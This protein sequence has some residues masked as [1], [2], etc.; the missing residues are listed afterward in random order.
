M[1]ISIWEEEY[2]PVLVPEISKPRARRG[3]YEIDDDTYERWMKAFSDFHN[4][5]TEIKKMLKEQNRKHR[6]SITGF[7]LGE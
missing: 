4:M 3:I 6:K 5:Q 7:K 2:Y 1:K